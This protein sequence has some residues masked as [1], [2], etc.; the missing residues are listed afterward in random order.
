M[1]FLNYRRDDAKGTA[2]R[3]HD[4]LADSFGR[5]RLFM[6]VDSIPVGMDF[7]DHL[8]RQVDVCDIFIAIIGPNWLETRDERGR[9]RLSAADD[10]VALEIEAALARDIKVIPVLVDGARMPRA[11]ELPAPLQPLARRQA[12]NLRNDHFGRDAEVLVERI[13]EAL[14]KKGALKWRRSILIIVTGCLVLFLAS[15][16]LFEWHMQTVRLLELERARAIDLGKQLDN[17]RDLINK[18]ERDVKPAAD[19]AAAAR[20]SAPAPQTTNAPSTTKDKLELRFSDRARTAPAVAF[21]SAQGL[22]SYPV[23]GPKIEGFGGPDGTGGMTKGITLAARP[24]SR[25]TAPADG[26]VVYAGPFRSYGQLIILNVGGGYHVLIAGMERIS[27]E[28]GQFVLKGDA[29][30]TMGK[31]SPPTAIIKAPGAMGIPLYVEFRKDG[32]PIDP[33]PWWK[34][35]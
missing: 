35:T 28:I 32:N 12:F 14:P 7:V 5:K 26:W 18:V 33:D 24:N 10:F 1:I 23:D 4:R 16:A 19:A 22:L 30:A 3:L 21:G 17:V 6:D 9:R 8:R 13:R 20:D 15:A 34:P 31:T 29:I 27:A 25:V 11:S 2:G